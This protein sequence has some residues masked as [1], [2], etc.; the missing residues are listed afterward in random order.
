MTLLV[1]FAHDGRPTVGVA[2]GDTVTVL[3]GTTV[4]EL[5]AAGAEAFAAALA[6]ADGERLPADGLE[7]LPPVDGLTEVWAAGVTYQRSQQARVEESS[8][9]SV[10]ELVYSA[11]RPEL[12]FKAPAWRAAG[13]GEPVRL[14]ADSGNDVPEPELGLVTDRTGTIVGY[15]VGND[16]TSRAIEGQNPLYLPQAKIWRGST[17]LGPGIRPVADV[18]DATALGISLTIHRNGNTEFHGT[19]ST[20]Q[21]ARTYDE[22]VGWLYRELDFPAGAVL[23]T[24]T[25]IVPALSFTL[26]AGD[27]VEIT[28]AGVG[29]LSNP[30]A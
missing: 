23:L 21:L 25:C 28:I 2:E 9:A 8:Q 11:E 26:A 18:A 22:L 19:A 14:R 4:A 27:V 5:L 30:V 20:A 16:L 12:F 1:R 24:G 17:A 13:P 6:A 10:Y 29:T 7:Y 3:P 15:L